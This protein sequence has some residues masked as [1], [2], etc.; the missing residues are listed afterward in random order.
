MPAD[1]ALR[2]PR[3]SLRGTGAPDGAGDGVEAVSFRSIGIAG[4][5]GEAEKSGRFLMECTNREQADKPSN[6]VPTEEEYRR[7]DEGERK[8]I[9]RESKTGDQSSTA[10]GSS[11]KTRGGQYQGGL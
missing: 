3:F 9:G 5:V 11:T 7:N 2:E 1:I 10:P 4:A 8:M 6:P